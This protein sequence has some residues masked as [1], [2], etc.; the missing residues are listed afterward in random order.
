L[1]GNGNGKSRFACVCDVR[2]VEGGWRWR[3]W[4]VVEDLI[5][6][7]LGI[8]RYVVHA[9]PTDFHVRFPVDSNTTVEVEAHTAA[10]A[11]VAE[12]GLPSEK[13]S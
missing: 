12:G 7:L 11:V 10:V 1:S 9:D 4:L 6:V 8:V 13:A 2:E 3:R 5:V